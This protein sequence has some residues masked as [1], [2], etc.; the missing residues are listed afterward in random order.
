VF[1]D[2]VCIRDCAKP[3]RA[4]QVIAAARMLFALPSMSA[5]L[6]D[7]AASCKPLAAFGSNLHWRAGFSKESCAV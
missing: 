2:P 6:N 1:Q 3:Q 7:V 4:A 5:K